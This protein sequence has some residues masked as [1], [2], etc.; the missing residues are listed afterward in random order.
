M[1]QNL[2]LFDQAMDLI[3]AGFEDDGEM[4]YDHGFECLWGDDGSIFGKKKALAISFVAN[5]S[6]VVELK[7]WA[8]WI[9]EKARSRGVDC[10][11]EKKTMAF[12]GKMT[13]QMSGISLVCYAL[14]YDL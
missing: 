5:K 4:K 1:T 11:E 2:I 3:W 12:H 9:R 13:I 10:L 6:L 8:H 14:C 7:V